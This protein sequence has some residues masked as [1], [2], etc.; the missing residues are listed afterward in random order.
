MKK[1][2][3]NKFTLKV[4][5]LI[6]AILI[7]LLVRNVDDPIVVRTFYEIPVSIENASY[8]AENLEIPLLVDGK[9]TVKVRVKG[10]RSV[11]SKLKKEDIKAVADMTQIISKDTT[12]I[13]VP[14]E[15]TGTGISDSDITVRPRNIQVDIE[16]QKSVEKT[17][18]VSTGDT[19]P[20]KDYEIGNLK[21]NPEKVT[22]SGPETIINKIDK[23]VALIDVTGR[24]ESNIEIKSQLKIYDK[25]LDELSPKQLEYLNIK[26]ISDNTIRIQAQFWKV[27]Q[28]VKIKA[29]YSGE[30]KRG[31]EVDSIN[32]VPDTISVAGT[33]EALKKL[34]QEGNTL[35]IPGKYIDVTDKAGDFEQN[36]DLSELLPEDLKLVRDLNSSVIATVKILPYNSRDYEV[37][38]TQ[39][40]ADNKAEDLDLVFQDEQIT[41]RAKAKEQDL[42][43]LSAANIQV[44]IDLSGYG[45]GEYEVPVTVTLPGG[46][47]LV[48]SIKVKVKLVPGA[49][50]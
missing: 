44:Q 47:E 9:D 6:I 34:E 16:K 48:E 12:P 41:I 4:L 17:I 42:D 38:V 33:D 45:E 13:M 23:V 40:E 31:Y 29:E 5:S 46:Y 49:E 22:I 3:I 43:S 21:A 36:I 26:E 24:K 20:D 1:N 15:V 19:Q 27:K 14:V 18:A 30:P 10:A 11:V 28:N 7:W 8:L 32:L 39:I 35:E 25:N 2:M 50:K 37:S